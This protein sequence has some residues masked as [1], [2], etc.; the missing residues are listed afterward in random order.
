M[1]F[2]KTLVRVGIP[3]HLQTNGEFANSLSAAGT[4]SQANST[5]LTADVNI[6]TT[7]GAT[8]AG[9]RLPDYDVGDELWIVNGGANTMLLYPPV[10]HYINDGAKDGAYTVGVDKAVLAKRVTATRWIVVGA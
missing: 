2:T 10:D 5:L 6:V 7:V 3:T 4:S 1:T 9:C 8:T